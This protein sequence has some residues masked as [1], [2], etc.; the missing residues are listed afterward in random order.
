MGEEVPQAPV[1]VV[2]PQAPVP[3]V[4]PNAPVP[5]VDPNPTPVT[6]VDDDYWISYA[7]KLV[8]D[9]PD[10]FVNSAG[11]LQTYSSAL[12]G[13]YIALGGVTA[14]FGAKEASFGTVEGVL[15]AAPA[16]ALIVAYGLATRATMP[17]NMRFY[18]NEPATIREAYNGMTATRRLQTRSAVYAFLA[19]TLLMVVGIFTLAIHN[20]KHEEGLNVS[21]ARAS[22]TT[23][24]LQISMQGQP[25][26]SVSICVR[27]ENGVSPKQ[28]VYF[29]CRY[30]ILRNGSLS[31]FLPDSVSRIPDSG[32]LEVS[33]SWKDE[34]GATRSIGSMVARKASGGS[35]APPSPPQNASI[36]S[37]HVDLPPNKSVP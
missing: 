35:S 13:L 28:K 31:L 12:W 26:D 1:P 15:L 27:D 37:N 7:A 29:C 6:M 17:V 36:Q 2:D 33:A 24:G 19:A 14:I 10:V 34:K 4:D 21:A 20:S 3:V 9:S 5:A 30:K 23:P 22:D 18:P 32:T 8:G 11:K 16:A 25:D